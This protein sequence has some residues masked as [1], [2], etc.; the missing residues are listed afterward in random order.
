M[1]T[2]EWSWLGVGERGKWGVV[3]KMGMEFQFCNK[4]TFW[5]L[6]AQREYN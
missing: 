5:R 4:K 6:A 2:V 1:E 3:I